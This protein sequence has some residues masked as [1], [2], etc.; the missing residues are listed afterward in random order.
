MLARPGLA[1]ECAEGVV[2]HGGD[3]LVTGQL[4]VRLDA[5]LHAV[6]LPVRHGVLYNSMFSHQTNGDYLGREGST[7]NI[8]SVM[9][10]WVLLSGKEKQNLSQSLFKLTA[11]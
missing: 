6:Q 7:E 8:F 4:A 2:R 3:G 1:E 10:R 11:N 5:V 9:F